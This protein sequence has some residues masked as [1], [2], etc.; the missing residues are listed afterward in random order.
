MQ[1]S[2]PTDVPSHSSSPSTKSLPHVPQVDVSK[3][4]QFAAHESVPLSKPSI[5]VKQSLPARLV[6]SQNS[7][8]SITSLPHVPQAEVSKVQS[9]AQSRLPLSKPWLTQL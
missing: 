6:P 1:V 9:A 8:P 7:V 2:P 5:S 4:V 3:P